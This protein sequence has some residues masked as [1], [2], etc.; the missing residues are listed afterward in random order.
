VSSTRLRAVLCVV[1]AVL[2]QQSAPAAAAPAANLFATYQATVPPSA[3]AGL[4]LQVPVTITNAGTDAWNA[5]GVNPVNLSYHWSDATGRPVVWDGART[6]LGGDLPAGAARQL[7]VAIAMPA[8]PGPY[9]LQLAVVK[10]GIAWLNP[11]TTFPVQATPAFNATW[12]GVQVPALLNSTTYTVN[13]PISN[14]GVAAWNATGPNLVDL[15]YHWTNAAGQVVVWDGVRTPL[16]ADVPPSGSTT[17]AATV[18]TPA[19]TGAYTLTFDLVREGVAWFA[20]LGAVPLKITTSVSPALYAAAYS[21]SGTAQAVL[22]ERRTIPVTVTNRGNVPWPAAGPNAVNLSYHVLAANGNVLLWDGGRTGIG[23]DLL[24]G[25][26]RSINVAYVAPTS[27]GTYTLAIDT[28]REG[29]AWLSQIGSPYATTPLIVTSGFNGGYDQTST[30]GL[31]TVGATLLLSV[32]VS[33]YGAR[34]WP[35]GGPNPVH[36]SYHI[37]TSGGSPVIWD[38]QRGLLVADLAVGQSAVVQVPVALPSSTGDYLIAWDLVQEGVAWFSQLNIQ[39]LQEPIS[40]QPGVTFYGKGFGHGV[41]M[42]Q[43]G[44]QGWATGASGPPLSGEQIVAKYYPG[45]Q[46]TGVDSSTNPRGPM[47]VLLSAPSSSGSASCGSAYMLTWLVNVRSAGGFNVLNEAGGN[48]VVGTA[49]ANVTFQIAASA[50]GVKVYDQSANPPAL[51][52]SGP[53]PV[54]L[55]PNDLNAPITVQ[56]K[57]EFF[58]G[59]LQFKNDGGGNLRVVNFVGYD[60]YVRGVIPKEMPNGWHLE[61]Y[62]AQA[63]AARTY[64]FTSTGPGRD[65]DVR[66]DQSD[67]CYGG[68]TVETTPGNQAV[69][70]TAGKVITYNGAAIRAY[71]ASS[72]GGYT[73]GVGCWN[74][75]TVCK[76]N[77]PYLV[78]VADPADLLVQVPIPNKHASWIVTFTSATIRAAILNYRGVDIGT[79]LSTD[80]SNQAPGNVGHVVSVRFSG[81]N[82]TVDVPADLFLRTYLGLKSTMVRLSPF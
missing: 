61:A 26:S 5:T 75:G 21:V 7:T 53:G 4:Q 15:S 38:G 79:L 46:L 40:V 18:T 2:F 71:F 80:V 54:T 6:P 51:K 58:R 78:P 66:D 20:S 3:G 47:R 1:V 43:Y 8:A 12:G 16:P 28:V 57:G 25:E 50:G 56:E 36:L 59:R 10:E 31:A 52:Y 29:I 62:K 11:S 77:D 33:N 73:V 14:S 64:G 74:T 42:S 35:A 22:G 82:A 65:Y 19:A 72:S 39:R 23:T 27:I 41:G 34:V 68:A 32:R 70:A 55:V 76:P 48:A 60:D 81:T 9:Q 17:V 45:T 67:Q 44:A 30:P 13:V 37:L 69:A 63:L 49:S 24:P